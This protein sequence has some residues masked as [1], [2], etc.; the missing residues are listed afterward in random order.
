MPT[1][2]NF[3]D[4]NI[5]IYAF[6]NDDKAE[7]AQ[8]IMREPFVLSVQALNE[9]INVG[10]RKL[11][12][13]W[14][15][16]KDA[17]ADIELLAAKII[18]MDVRLTASALAIGERYTLSFYDALMLAAALEA[19]CS[20]FYSEDLHHGLVIDGTLEVVNPFRPAERS[21]NP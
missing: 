13:P 10:R 20:R 19:K 18:P 12:L 1:I 16:L 4:T 8:D 7:I 2:G 17:I 5:L 15:R 9:F 21:I 3:L 14:G 6:S 11:Q